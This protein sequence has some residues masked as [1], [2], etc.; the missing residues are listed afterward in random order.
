METSPGSPTKRYFH[1]GKSPD[2]GNEVHAKGLP[3]TQ[4]IQLDLL[5]LMSQYKLSNL[6]FLI[7]SYKTPYSHSNL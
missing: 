5:P 2:G 6:L 3:L 4:L 1:L 7:K